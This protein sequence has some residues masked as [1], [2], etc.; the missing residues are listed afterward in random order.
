MMSSKKASF[1]PE[2]FVCGYLPPFLLS[3]T[4][5]PPFWILALMPLMSFLV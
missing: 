2:V 5:A 3:G 1:D 4:F